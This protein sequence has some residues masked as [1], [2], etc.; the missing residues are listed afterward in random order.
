MQWTYYGKVSVTV[1]AGKLF[2]F[3]VLIYNNTYNRYFC[4]LKFLASLVETTSS[5]DK[6]LEHLSGLDSF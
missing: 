2:N 1:I 3:K 4:T 5:D 6:D